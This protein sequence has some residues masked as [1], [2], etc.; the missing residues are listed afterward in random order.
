MMDAL[1]ALLVL[2]V[3]TATSLLSYG[4]GFNRGWRDAL[5]QQRWNKWFTKTQSELRD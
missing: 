3:W 1:F 4:V 5:S 2:A